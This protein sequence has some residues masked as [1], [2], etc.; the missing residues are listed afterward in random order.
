MAAYAET[1]DLINV[2][3]YHEGTNPTVDEAI[4][5][6][7]AIESMLIQEVGEQS[8]MPE[9]LAL[10]AA[11]TGMD[12]PLEEAGIYEQG[13]VPGTVAALDIRV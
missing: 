7:E 5:K 1:E 10:M 3:A 11:I 6:R 9:T 2:G 4:A 12:I 13:K 8:S